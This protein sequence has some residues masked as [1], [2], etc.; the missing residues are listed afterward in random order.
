MYE[1]QHV[2]FTFDVKG[3]RDSRKLNRSE[4]NLRVGNRARVAATAAVG[5][6]ELVLPSGLNLLISCTFFKVQ[7]MLL[8]LIR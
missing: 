5:T 6:C 2:V 1:I 4:M 7:T 3:L 8:F